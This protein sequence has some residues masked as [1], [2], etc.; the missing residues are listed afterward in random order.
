MGLHYLGMVFYPLPVGVDM[1]DMKSIAEYISIAPLASLLFVML[2][3]IGRTF[4]AGIYN[5]Y[6]LPH[7]LWF[8]IEVIFYFPAAIYIHKLISKQ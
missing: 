6:M 5:L 8:N 3:H 7:P 4:I 1:N 2:A